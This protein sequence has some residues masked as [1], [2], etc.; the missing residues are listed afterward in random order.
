M[1]STELLGGPLLNYCELKI[2]AL[3]DTTQSVS[4]KKLQL[5][6]HIL[7]STFSHHTSHHVPAAQAEVQCTDPPQILFQ[8]MKK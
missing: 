2:F 6:P 1:R 3:K 4:A 8:K 7:I 5:F